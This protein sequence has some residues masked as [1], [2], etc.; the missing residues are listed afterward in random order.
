LEQQYL[1]KK[2]TVSYFNTIKSGFEKYPTNTFMLESLVNYYLLTGKDLNEGLNY[3]NEAI[4]LSPNIAQYYCVRGNIYEVR[5]QFEDAKK[6]YDKTVELDAGNALA[7][8]GL[9]KYYYS[10]AETVMDRISNIRDPKVLNAEK[11]KVKEIYQTAA[12]EFEKCRAA[13]SKNC[14]NLNLLKQTYFRIYQDTNNPKYKEV[15][16]AWKDCQ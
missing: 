5:Q 6:D 14:G 7:H 1:V 15:N 2:D 4:K 3:L 13:D 12:N 11:E 9:G 8:F 10:R 16:Q